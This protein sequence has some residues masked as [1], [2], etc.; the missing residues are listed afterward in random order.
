MQPN[1]AQRIWSCSPPLTRSRG[2]DGGPRAN[3]LGTSKV[4]LALISSTMTLHTLTIAHSYALTI[5]CTCCHDEIKGTQDQDLFSCSFSILP[6]PH[7][8]S[9]RI[10][11]SNAVV[12]PACIS[13]ADVD[14]LYSWSSYLCCSHNHVSHHSNV[15]I[16][17]QRQKICTHSHPHH[18]LLLSLLW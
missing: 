17:R 18:H 7:H 9:A 13:F 10:F 8:W 12:L 5:T 2:L 16:R 4:S 3:R 14:T 6:S 15:L 11:P 1:T